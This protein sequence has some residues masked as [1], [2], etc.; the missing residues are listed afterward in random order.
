[1]TTIEKMALAAWAEKFGVESPDEYLSL[2]E[3]QWRTLF[4]EDWLSVVRA[5]LQ[6][7]REPDETMFLAGSDALSDAWSP[8]AGRVIRRQIVPPVFTAMI[9]AILRESA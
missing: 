6:A 9:D 2:H 1:M 8:G 3:D 7:I 4:R 5:A